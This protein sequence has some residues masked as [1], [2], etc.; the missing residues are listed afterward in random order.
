MLEKE[1]I[2]RTL[3]HAIEDEL[4]FKEKGSMEVT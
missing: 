1:D 3:V 4:S 2:F